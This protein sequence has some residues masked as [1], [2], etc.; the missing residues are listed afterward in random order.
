[1]IL[2][3][4]LHKQYASVHAVN[5]VTLEARPGE[6]FG[7]LGPNGAGKSTTIRMINNIIEPDSGTITYDGRP[8]SDE[9]RMRIGYLPEERGLYQK[10]RI[11]ETVLYFARL[12][13]VDEKAARDRA[14]RWLRRFDLAGSERRKVEEL[15]KGNQQKIQ[16]VIALVH[17]PAYLIFDEPASGLDPV[18]QETLREIVEELRNDGRTIVYSTHQMELAE[19]LCNRI[20]LINRGRVVLAG[21]VGQVRAEHGANSVLVEF[22]GDGAFLKTLPPVVSADIGA[23]FAELKLRPDASL[24]DLLPHIAGRIR[25]SKIER[26]RPSL[27]SIFIETVARRGDVDPSFTSSTEATR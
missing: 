21:T 6:I 13:G 1:M 25:V 3:E 12:H 7:L 26:V 17:E 8:F 23:N 14:A 27:K 20:A 16:I 22:Q 4:H 11:L 15:S 24:D 19:R 10:A 2:A 9:V 18:N 5:D